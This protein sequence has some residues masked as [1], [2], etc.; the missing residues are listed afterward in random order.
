MADIFISYSRTDRNW[1][2]LLAKT[3]ESE[4]WDVWWDRD[5]V[6]GDSFRQTI[7]RE[8]NKASCVLVVWSRAS[9][10]SRWVNDEADEGQS[11]QVMLPIIIDD[12]RPPI[13]FRSIQSENFIDWKGDRL[14]DVFKSLSRSIGRHATLKSVVKPSTK[15][16]T[17]K[18]VDGG[19]VCFT[20]STEYVGQE[21]EKEIP[22]V[23]GVLGHFSGTSEFR[24][25]AISNRSFVTTSLTNRDQVISGMEPSINF[26]VRNRLAAFQDFPEFPVKLSFQQFSDFDASSIQSNLAIL[27]WVTTFYRV[28]NQLTHSTE[29]QEQESVEA[30]FKEHLTPPNLLIRLIELAQ[31][32][33]GKYQALSDEESQTWA[34]QWGQFQNDNPIVLGVL[35]CLIDELRELDPTSMQTVDE[36]GQRISNQLDEILHA[37]KFQKLEAS[38][39]GLDLLLSQNVHHVDVVI[40]IFD[41]SKSEMLVDLQGENFDNTII[42]RK[43]FEEQYGVADGVPFGLILGDWS[44]G[45]SESDLELVQIL[46]RIA[47]HSH[48]PMVMSA[49]DEL[50]DIRNQASEIRGTTTGVTKEFAQKSVRSD[51]KQFRLNEQSHYI[52]LTGPKVLLRLPYSDPRLKTGYFRGDK[53]FVF[54]ETINDRN[55]YLWGNAVYPLASS[56]TRTYS[57]FGW[58]AMLSHPLCGGNISQLPI[59]KGV[60]ERVGPTSISIS[61]NLEL[62]LSENGLLP[63]VQNLQ[64][65]SANFNTENTLYLQS[66]V[67]KN[68]SSIDQQSSTKLSSIL[69]LTRIMQYLLV[70]ARERIGSFM[71]S[72]SFELYLNN[73]L[74]PYVTKDNTKVNSK[75]PLLGANVI[76]TPVKGSVDIYDMELSLVAAYQFNSPVNMKFKTRIAGFF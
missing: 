72:S 65:A 71:G 53:L 22:L 52:T 15:S 74:M 62:E 24:E 48:L 40:K 63:L 61:E 41:V 35:N 76:I 6:A 20:Y 60:D 12:I 28:L 46:A 57:R 11:R 5:L 58:Y 19:K 7:E 56:I 43:L 34:L 47:S 8:L 29:T 1:I 4:G 66:S 73:W 16:N 2:K 59:Y 17:T 64:T 26:R 23:V 30:L 67:D 33:D 25:S 49:N 3:L 55:H 38:W 9:I 13:G 32:K 27:K 10:E 18:F 14:A 21:H 54:S 51:W 50:M 31:Q 45:T 68:V 70:I 36:L 37:R 42:F 44:I 69:T 39:R 75:Q